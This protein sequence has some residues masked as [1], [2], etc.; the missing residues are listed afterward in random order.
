MSSRPNRFLVHLSDEE[1]AYID[2]CARIRDITV[3]A[4]INRIVR[5]TARDQLVAGL[6][7]DADEM[8]KRARGEHRYRP[9]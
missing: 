8:R 3:S 9:Y 4:L 6:L 2:S 5:T 7:D 1:L